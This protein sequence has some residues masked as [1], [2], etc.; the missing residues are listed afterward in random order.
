VSYL[1]PVVAGE[2]DVVESW[3]ARPAWQAEAACRGMGTELFFPTR[4]EPTRAA[5]AVCAGCPV[6]AECLDYALSAHGDVRSERHGIW[7][8][9][10]ERERRQVRK[11]RRAARERE[12][13]RR[14]S[15]RR[16]PSRSSA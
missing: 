10:S 1:V 5:K 11:G 14:A 8:G 16:H 15:T 7:A 2:P 13:S 4:G 3:L 12:A 6:S 9:T